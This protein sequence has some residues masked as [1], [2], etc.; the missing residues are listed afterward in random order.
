MLIELA[1]TLAT[2]FM[3]PVQERQ[4]ASR[5]EIIFVR[6]TKVP[7]TGVAPMECLQIRKP[8]DKEWSNLYGNI[9]GFK[10]V[11]GYRYRL[12]VR[13]SRVNNPPADASSIQYSL[14]KILNRTKVKELSPNNSIGNAL[15]KRWTLVKM[16]GEE[17]K[18]SGIWME[19]DTKENRMHGKSGCNGMMGGYT[20]SVNNISFTKTAGTLMACPDSNMM[21]REYEFMKQLGDQSF[22]IQVAGSMVTLMQQGTP[23]FQF[24]LGN[25]GDNS[26]GN[27]NMALGGRKWILTKLN[28]TDVSNATGMFLM[29]DAQKKRFS[30]KGGCNNI[31]GAYTNNNNTISFKQAASTRMACTDNTVAQRESEFIKTLS[32]HS[33]RYEIG[34]GTLSLYNNDNL[35]MQFI[36]EGSQPIANITLGGRRWTLEKLNDTDLSDVTGMYLE[37]DARKKRFSGKGGCNNISGAYTNINNTITFKQAI[38]TRMACLDNDAAQRESEFLK[39][40]SDR[41]YRY[42]IDDRT[43]NLYDNDKLVMQ[44]STEG[45]HPVASG[46]MREWAFIGSKKWNVIKLNDETLANSGIWL[47]FDINKKRYN[48]KGGCNNI[49]GTYTSAKE[50]ITFSRAISTRMACPDPN[51]MRRES[52]FLNLLSEK[53]YRF[54]IADQTLNLYDKDGKIVIMFG[55]QNK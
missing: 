3:A 11:P 35:V 28:G 9:A 20:L 10:Y 16:N 37:F 51:V 41:S 22:Q 26:S 1:I 45:S 17:L 2:A 33:Y 49:A 39:T 29:F 7:C 23:V 36:T 30:G 31:F 27:V 53:T 44:F 5:T 42:E 55:M 38:S 48:G 46:N 19:F 14:I 24:R 8:E 25:K 6:E 43:L 52:T 4:Q 18:Q 40:L 15:N 50:D 34:E 47:Q 12:R 32:D 21:R 54:D 13:V